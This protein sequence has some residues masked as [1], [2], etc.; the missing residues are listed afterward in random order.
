MDEEKFS[1]QTKRR[2]EKAKRPISFGRL[3]VEDMPDHSCV[4]SASAWEVEEQM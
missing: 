1:F 2:M 4:I 3:K